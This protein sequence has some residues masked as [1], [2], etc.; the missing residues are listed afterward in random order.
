MK[1]LQRPHF[2]RL[3][4]AT[5]WCTLVIYL[6][7]AHLVYVVIAGDNMSHLVFEAHLLEVVNTHCW[8]TLLQRAKYLKR[9]FGLAT[10]PVTKTLF[11]MRPL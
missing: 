7:P 3:K 10:G 2:V 9:A 4:Y 11:T 1:I 6:R 5:R 8:N